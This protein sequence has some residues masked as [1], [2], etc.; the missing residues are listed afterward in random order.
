VS[1]NWSL[2]FRFPYWNPV[3]ISLL[4]HT[5]YMAHPSRSPWFDHL[6]NI[7]WSIKIITF[8]I[9]NLSS[10]LLLPFHTRY[11]PQHTILKY[12]WPTCLP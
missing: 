8:L 4:P 10:L 5:C 3:H 12:T 7:W 2:S 9:T 6:N 1:S 11:L